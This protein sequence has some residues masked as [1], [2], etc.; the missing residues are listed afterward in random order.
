MKHT[1]PHK[2]GIMPSNVLSILN[3][4][5]ERKKGHHRTSLFSSLDILKILI[6]KS[7]ASA[8]QI[9]G[10]QYFEK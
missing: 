3:V 7:E 10:K 2:I 6:R 4:E 1:L 8:M 5:E 9:C